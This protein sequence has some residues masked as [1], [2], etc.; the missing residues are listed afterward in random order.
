MESQFMFSQ[1]NDVLYCLMMLLYVLKKK[2]MIL[3]TISKI[4]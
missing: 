2:N 4:T 3:L 1:Y